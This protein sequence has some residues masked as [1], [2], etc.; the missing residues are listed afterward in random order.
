MSDAVKTRDAYASKKYL[1]TYVNFL[2]KGKK[3]IIKLIKDVETGNGI[4]SDA[5]LIYGMHTKQ[6]RQ[7]SKQRQLN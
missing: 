3:L 5:R 2:W 7:Q 6:R 1:G 4:I